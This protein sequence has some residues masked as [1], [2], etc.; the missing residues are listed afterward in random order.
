MN[1]E[2][3]APDG[4]LQTGRLLAAP[5]FGHARGVHASSIPAAVAAGRAAEIQARGDRPGHRDRHADWAD[6]VA[7]GLPIPALAAR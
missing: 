1:G 7:P 5:Q 2:H 3:C 4:Q 6:G